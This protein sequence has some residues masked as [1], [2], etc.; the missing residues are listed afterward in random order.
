MSEAPPPSR[1]KE[2][3]RRA[4]LWGLRAESVAAVYLRLHGYRILARRYSAAGGEID[5]IASRGDV[6]AFVEVKARTDT[7]V[8]AY[9]I[10]AQKVRR[11][12]QAARHWLARHPG[13]E[14]KVW[15]GDAILL[16]PWRWPRHVPDFIALQIS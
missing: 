13:A 3:R 12:S 4:F 16:S 8:A 10:T 1:F 7:D 5:L 2:R 15:R 14:K 9:S 6:I 11:I